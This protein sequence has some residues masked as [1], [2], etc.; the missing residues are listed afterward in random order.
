MLFLLVLLHLRLRRMYP[1]AAHGNLTAKVTFER[2]INMACPGVLGL[3]VV[4][5]PC[6]FHLGE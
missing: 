1:T 3:I 6:I 4:W 2:T 5:M